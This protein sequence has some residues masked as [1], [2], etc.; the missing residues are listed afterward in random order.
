M[1]YSQVLCLLPVWLKS[2]KQF[3]SFSTKFLFKCYKTLWADINIVLHFFI[4]LNF[5]SKVK[6]LLA[7]LWGCCASC[8]WN[9]TLDGCGII[10]YQPWVLELKHIL[11]QHFRI[12]SKQSPGQFQHLAFEIY[13]LIWTAKLQYQF[14]FVFTWLAH[15][16]FPLRKQKKCLQTRVYLQPWFYWKLYPK[17]IQVVSCLTGCPSNSEQ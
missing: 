15:T 6:G 4:P 11:L 1:E 8:G 14:R 2:D 16:L 7:A 10:F 5:L 3:C 12:L 17:I 13:C 9:S